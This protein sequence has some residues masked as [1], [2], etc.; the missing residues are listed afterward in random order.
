MA[1]GKR[2][3]ADLDGLMAEL[4][5]LMAKIDEGKIHDLRFNANANGELCYAL[6]F[7]TGEANFD[8]DVRL[9]TFHE[10]EDGN[11]VSVAADGGIVGQKIFD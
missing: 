8:G 11:L 2:D 7:D 10:D 5:D 3:R 1:K 6:D 4:D 9:P